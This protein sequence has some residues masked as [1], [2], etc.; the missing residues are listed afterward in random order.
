MKIKS[1]VNKKTLMLFENHREW[2]IM[3]CR[4]FLK[5]GVVVAILAMYLAFWYMCE[6]C[7]FW[8]AGLSCGGAVLGA[9]FLA[10]ACAAGVVCSL[11]KG[12]HLG[13]GPFHFDMHWDP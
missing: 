9:P 4:A 12:V 5:V 2:K 13:T 6:A 8:L 11:I 3:A 7:V 1:S 10:P